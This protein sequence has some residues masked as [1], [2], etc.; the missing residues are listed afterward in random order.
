MAY[1]D[2]QA[3][4][5]IDRLAQ[6][7][8]IG[9]T[10]SG[11]V[12]RLAL[13]DEDRAGRDLLV[14]WMHDTGLEVRVD[15]GGNIFG[16]TASGEDLPLIAGS[17]IDSVRE[18][19]RFDG[20]LGVLAAL[21]AVQALAL[22]GSHHRL[23]VVAFTNEE[24]ARFR[25]ALL[26]SGLATGGFD[27]DFVLS[28]T[29]DG[30]A[31][32]GQELRRIG[33]AGRSE[34]RL[35]AAAAF[36]E[37]HI[38]QGPVLEAR[39]ATIGAVQG[40]VGIR[41]LEFTVCGRPDHAGPTPMSMR[42][43]ALVTAA[44]IATLARDLARDGG[45]DAV[46]TVGRFLVHP[47]VVNVIPGEVIFNVDIRAPEAGALQDLVGAL[48][49]GAQSI[50]AEEGCEVCCDTLWDSP[51]CAFNPSVVAAVRSA[52]RGLGVEPVDIWSGASH[53]A[54][55]MADRTPTGMIFVPSRAGIS[56]NP[57]EYTEEAHCILG[58]RVL[59]G[60]LRHLDRRG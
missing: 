54:R 51:A 26:G 39:S 22:E 18:G 17:H 27:A 48:L 44:R 16:V 28:R 30:G 52:A 57:N 46:V 37:L 47:N 11:G 60:T 10:P 49:G 15:D 50:G 32:F 24:G 2:I 6:L 40:I 36:L 5:L 31:R 20:A 19:G 8:A 42:Q 38:E 33:Y 23:G 25:P 41:W 53:D 4:R 58:A 59:L 29:D 45:Q 7:S 3:E 13:S 1:L 43:D 35:P 9:A 55:M 12:S 14:Q 21:E 56:H 34:F